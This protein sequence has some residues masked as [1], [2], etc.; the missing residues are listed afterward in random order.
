M[1]LRMLTHSSRRS[2]QKVR[3]CML[4][5]SSR[6]SIQ[7]VHLCMLTHFSLVR[8]FITPEAVA[9]QSPLSMRFSWQEHCSGVSCFLPRF[10][11]DPEIEPMV[12]CIS[13]IAAHSG[14]LIQGVAYLSPVPR[15]MKRTTYTPVHYGSGNPHYSLRDLIVLEIQWPS[16]CICHV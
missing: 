4:T 6:R 12:S 7:G 10:L 11:P 3:L 1:R 13:C 9:H 15:I 14:Q 2:I 16:L 5:H 8:L